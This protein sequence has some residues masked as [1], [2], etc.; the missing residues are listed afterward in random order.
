MEPALSIVSALP[1]SLPPSIPFFVFWTSDSS[2]S[3]VV[4]RGGGLNDFHD[5]MPRNLDAFPFPAARLAPPDPRVSS[6]AAHS[7]C[8]WDDGWPAMA[9]GTCTTQS[10]G[11]GSGALEAATADGGDNFQPEFMTVFTDDRTGT[12][13]IYFKRTDMGVTFP[14]IAD[15]TTSCEAGGTALAMLSFPLIASCPA[16]EE[17][18]DRYIL[19]YGSEDSEGVTE[20]GPFV[21]RLVIDTAFTDPMTVDVPGLKPNETYHFLLLA[22]DEARSIFPPSFDPRVATNTAAD[23]AQRWP[24]VVMPDCAP[25]CIVMDLSPIALL[26][27]VKSG[28]DAAFSWTPDPNAPAYHLNTVEFKRFLTGTDPQSPHRQPTGQGVLQCTAL[29]SPTL[30]CTHADAILDVASPL[31]YQALSTCGD[32]GVDEGPVR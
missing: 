26:K 29:P 12:T 20:F 27:G 9:A 15:V 14:T 8:V 23:G 2:P 16:A 13:Q 10:R 30:G 11:A 25:N 19:Y 6:V 1:A 5:V 31:F 4:S 24:D 22:E 18:I 17:R 21:N 32:M 28:A 7:N 3:E